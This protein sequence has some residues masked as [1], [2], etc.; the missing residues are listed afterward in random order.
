MLLITCIVPAILVSG[1]DFTA[2]MTTGR[3]ESGENRTCT[4]VVI[5]PDSR[6]EDTEN[7][8]VTL[9]GSSSVVVS[10][11]AGTAIVFIDDDDGELVYN[12][13]CM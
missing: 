4:N 13:K 2:L 6:V 1:S 7:F 11:T 10:N 9:T 8:S 3:F 12:H 5:L